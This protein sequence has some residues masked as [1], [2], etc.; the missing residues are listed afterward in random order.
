M[1]DEAVFKFWW[2]ERLVYEVALADLSLQLEERA[3]VHT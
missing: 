3:N 1:W 2:K